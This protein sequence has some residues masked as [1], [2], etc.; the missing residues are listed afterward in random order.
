MNFS[1]LLFILLNGK[2]TTTTSKM[3]S[4]GPSTESGN[5][6]ANGEQLGKEVQY[7]QWG[8]MQMQQ[9]APGCDS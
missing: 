8:M 7:P 4:F 5:V 9:A 3:C 2:V 1:E 6:R